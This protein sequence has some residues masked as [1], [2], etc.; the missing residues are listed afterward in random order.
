MCRRRQHVS[1][2]TGSDRI[3]CSLTSTHKKTDKNV[4]SDSFTQTCICAFSSCYCF[5]NLRCLF[6]KIPIVYSSCRMEKVRNCYRRWNRR[7]RCKSDHSLHWGAEGGRFQTP[8]FVSLADISF[9]A[10]RQLFFSYFPATKKNNFIVF[11][12]FRYFQTFPSCS[13][14]I[15]SARLESRLFAWHSHSVP[16]TF[17]NLWDTSVLKQNKTKQKYCET[18]GGCLKDVRWKKNIMENA[19]NMLLSCQLKLNLSYEVMTK[20]VSLNAI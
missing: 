9:E 2:V 3:S 15:K 6:L 7:G 8:S 4:L 5:T 10:S 13:A 17:H 1:I 16:E 20:P 19:T 11:I 18:T 14:L 12:I